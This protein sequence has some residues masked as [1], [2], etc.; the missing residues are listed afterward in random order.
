MKKIIEKLEIKKHPWMYAALFVS[1]ILGI[2][3]V[4]LYI[5]G[6][7][8]DLFKLQTLVFLLI[9]LIPCFLVAITNFI[10]MKKF[11]KNPG[12]V[13]CVTA[14][15]NLCIIFGPILII[16]IG[17]VILLIVL[18][19]V[20]QGSPAV[21]NF[22]N[23][24][25]DYTKALESV[26]FQDTY[27]NHFPKEIPGNAKNIQFCKVTFAGKYEAM[28]LKFTTDD[29][30]Y[31]KNEIRKYKPINTFEG[32]TTRTTDCRAFDKEG[33]NDK[34]KDLTKEEQFKFYV[35]E[36]NNTPGER[37][38]KHGIA[39]NKKGDT[40]FY[41]TENP[42]EYNP[43]SADSDTLSADSDTQNTTDT[44]DESYEQLILKVRNQKK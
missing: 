15:L 38:Y 35:L 4:V 12:I 20:M 31:I 16:T 39:V 40:I 36:E 6:N 18:M 32:A 10:G 19:Y 33:Y 27:T 7:P 37:H 21:N 41:Y 43:L 9:S 5:K 25:E 3:P 23:N 8:E 26:A 1:M 14:I 24:P 11:D 30:D 13:K 42:D 34:Y 2:T 29:K 44:D 28:E 22:Y 17:G